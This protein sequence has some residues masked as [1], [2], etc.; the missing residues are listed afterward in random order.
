M[1]MGNASKILQ[2]VSANIDGDVVEDSL[3]Q[4]VDMILL[5][6]TSGLLTGE[7]EV[8]VQGVNVAIQRETQRQRQIELLQHT[9]NPV[10][11]K[12]MGIKGRANLLR[13]VSSNVGLDG[14]EIVPDEQDIDKMVSDEKNA[15]AQGNQAALEQKV[16][17]GIQKG[18]EAG[19]QRIATELTAGVLATRARLPEGPPVHIGTPP[20][21]A[22][23]GGAPPTGDLSHL[24]AQGQGNQAS[25]TS[26]SMGPQTA[27]VGNQP[28]PN[29]MPVKGGVG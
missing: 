20:G 29:A 22:P 19:V 3:L 24:A 13:S 4:L 18:V 26:Q 9:M 11:Q 23:P 15:Q 10:D 16:E 14:E 1:L 8:S 2:T 21:G 7:E 27:V 6:D 28:G 12:I 25:K 17:E 5:T